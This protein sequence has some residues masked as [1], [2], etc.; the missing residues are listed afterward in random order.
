MNIVDNIPYDDDEYDDDE[1][2]SPIENMSIEEYINSPNKKVSD[3]ENK[4]MMVEYLKNEKS[5]YKI[6]LF[7]TFVNA[8]YLFEAVLKVYNVFKIKLYC[9]M[10][11]HEMYIH[12]HDNTVTIDCAKKCIV[13]IKKR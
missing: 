13:E 8:G 11:L 7:E 1:Y 4:K 2:K 12:N 6:D 9:N 3:E 10:Y 5:K